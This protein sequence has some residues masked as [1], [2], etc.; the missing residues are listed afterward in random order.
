M[1]VV[2]QT[3][4]AASYTSSSVTITTPTG[5]VD[6]DLLIA[7]IQNDS[8]ATI[9][10]PAGWTA[11][12]STPGASSFYKIAASEGASYVFTPSAGSGVGTVARITGHNTT[13]PIADS[14]AAYATS[15]LTG[16]APSVTASVASSGLVQM[17][18]TT[19]S[20]SAWTAPGTATKVYDLV[21][22]SK[23]VAGGQETV[24]SGATGTRT[25]TANNTAGDTSAL[26]VAVNP[27]VVPG[28][29][30]TVKIIYRTNNTF[31]VPAGIT[32]I[33]VECEGG[34]AGG[35]NG[36]ALFVGGGGGGGAY[37]KS[38]LTVTPGSTHSIV[39][40][41]QVANVT[42]GNVSSF[43][44]GPLVLGAGGTKGANA[45]TTA[46]GAGGAGGT[47][48][49]SVGTIKTAGT[50]GVA[51]GAGGAGAAPLGGAGG[52]QSTLGSA[53]GGGGGGG[54]TLSTAGGGGAKGVVTVQWNQPDVIGEGVASTSSKSIT[55]SLNAIGDGLTSGTK[56]VSTSLYAIGEG[57]SSNNRSVDIPRT[58]VGE[59]LSD[60]IKSVAAVRTLDVVGEGLSSRSPFAVTRTLNAVGEGLSIGT[61]NVVAYKTLDVVGEGLTSEVHPVQAFRT[62][63]LAGKG[64]IVMNGANASTITMPLDEVPTGGAV[65]N[66]YIFPILD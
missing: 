54:A 51:G 8:S 53:P 65:A 13:S 41:A 15:S 55:R 7:L 48:A 22:S 24:G 9:T 28:S 20:S 2:V 44:T 42:N 26:S 25:W 23:N 16:I 47:T 58:A 60:F 66:T 30:G 62:F 10:P 33:D 1:A 64:E 35:G 27:P 32:S 49:A 57:L 50:A 43:G 56:A 11:I 36:S 4:N 63:N 19:G 3:A 18:Q 29:P 14:A 39:V 59:G 37:A 40:A 45:G 5:T 38:T 34:G 52:A 6:G 31:T 12:A 21:V 46:N 61:K 17:V